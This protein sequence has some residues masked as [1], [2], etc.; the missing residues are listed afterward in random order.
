MKVA[1]DGTG[2]VGATA[3]CAPVMRAV[4]RGIVPFDK[5]EK[6]ARTRRPP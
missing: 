6:L 1:T 5:N 4:P 3:A 2:L